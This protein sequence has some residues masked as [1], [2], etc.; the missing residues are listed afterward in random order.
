MDTLQVKQK[1]I[2]LDK[3]M[4]IFCP[5]CRKKHPQREFPLNSMEECAI[6]ELSHATSSFPSFPRLKAVFQGTGEEVDQLYFMGSKKPWQPR[7]PTINQGMFLDPSQC[8]NNFNMGLQSI[9]YPP[10]WTQ[11]QFPPWQ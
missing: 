9:P 3:A 1:Q 4:A 11:Y 2:E 5:K 6:C 10:M 7:P 8:F